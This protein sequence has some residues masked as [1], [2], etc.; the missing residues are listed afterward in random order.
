MI[1]GG[2]SSVEAN[3]IQLA[4]AARYEVISAASLRNFDLVKKFGAGRVFD[5][6]SPALISDIIAAFK[7]KKC[8]G[9]FAIRRAALSPAFDIISQIEGKKIV[10]SANGPAKDVLLEPR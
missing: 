10:I 4:V 9:A 5:Y 8:A 3:A 2:S 7:G 1:W 6:S